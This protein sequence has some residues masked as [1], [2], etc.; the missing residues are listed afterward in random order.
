MNERRPILTLEASLYL[1][2]FG[3]A[4][5]LRLLHLG[6]HPLNNAEARE[7]FTVLLRLRGAAP[8]AGLAPSSPAYFFFTYL[9]FL[10]FGASD[11]AARVGPALAGAVLVLVP[12]LYR[13]YL[14]RPAAL[15]GS[16]LVAFSS[17]LLA[18]S[19]S[20]DGAVFAL[21]GLAAAI[22]ALGLHARGA[23]RHWLLLSAAALGLG[24]A[25]GRTFVLGLLALGLTLLVLRWTQ[26]ERGAAWRSLWDAVWAKR[27]AFGVTLF[28][29]ALVVS[30][31]G[32]VYLR[33]LGA[34]LDGLVNGVGGFL[35]STPGRLPLEVLLFLF[36]YE[37]LL[38]VF[39]I[40]G[41]VRAFRGGHAVGQAL[42]WFALSALVLIVLHSGRS[43]SDVVW[44]VAPLALLAGG[45]LVDLLAPLRSRAD[46]PL[47]AAQGTL[48]C[49]LLGFALLNLAGLAELARRSPGGFTAF[50]VT[51]AGRIV[52]IPALA[53]FGVA[54]L[55]VLLTFVIA[56]LVALG[57]SANAARLGL[58]SAW[59]GLLTVATLAA[60]WGLTQW[61]PG[62]PGEL[63]WDR[64]ASPDVARLMDSL[65]AVSNY[66]VGNETDIAVTVEASVDGAL[67][68]AMRDFPNANFVDR[69][70]PVINS[71]V[72][73]A[74]ITEAHPTLGS[75]YVG[76]D[77]FVSAYWNLDLSPSE[78]VTWLAYRATPTLTA[79]PVILWVRQDVA[80]LTST[81]E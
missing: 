59:A 58:V 31:T 28:L 37:P 20:A 70:D 27:R 76:Q 55:A 40:V 11:A 3:V 21:L 4:L 17:G 64:T 71:P 8:D 1:L 32:L 50:Q 16:A 9:A 42:T 26:A 38:V 39:G 44:V 81:G 12:A 33:G 10:L 43:L 19:R 2:F 25:G 34:L 79:E 51:V 15:A 49:A 61:R 65:G 69:L 35:P 68:W 52:E 48:T 23:G 66:T 22:G 63:W 29:S 53:Q 54:L 57:W 60:G 18:A 47:A 14:G 45:A 74:P 41:A 46:W 72:V 56:Y 13:E 78:W 62:S 80:Q 7:A 30:T 36:A 75:T 73:I 67:A 5:A 77:F 24:L 6:A